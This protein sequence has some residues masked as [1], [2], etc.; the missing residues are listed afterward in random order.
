MEEVERTSQCCRMAE[1]P[2]ATDLSGGKTSEDSFIILMANFAAEYAVDIQFELFS[3][4]AVGSTMQ[5]EDPK[6]LSLGTDR[7]GSRSPT[8]H[9]GI[10]R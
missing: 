4:A 3:C 6:C 1:R 9:E 8:L 5:F 7:V 2:P 10:V